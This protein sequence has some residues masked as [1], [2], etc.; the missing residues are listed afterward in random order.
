MLRIIPWI[1]IVMLAV[2][3][4]E[5]EEPLSSVAAVRALSPAEAARH[6]A[7]KLEATITFCGEPPDSGVFIQDN[8]AGIFLLIPDSILAQTRFQWKDRVRVEAVTDPG[9]YLP[10]LVCKSVTLV[11]RDALP[12]A[13]PVTPENF[14]SP[15]L[16]SRWVELSGV[17]S[18]PEP[19]DKENLVFTLEFYGLK[20][21]VLT[22]WSEKTEHTIPTLIQQSVKLAAIEASLYNTQRQLTGCYLLLPS[23][24]CIQVLN[25][26]GSESPPP[27]LA[28]DHLLRSDTKADELVRVQGTVTWALNDEIHLRGE[29][30]GLR[31]V[32]VGGNK[33]RPGDRVEAEGFASIAPFRPIF[34]ARK[35]TLL[36]RGAEPAP[37]L[38]MPTTRKLNFQ[39]SEFVTTGAEFLGVTDSL[40][41]KYL[42]CRVGEWFFEAILTKP[43]ALPSDLEP[44]STLQ[45][46][47]ICELIT[48][49]SL[50]RSQWVDGFRIRLRDSSD[51]KIIARPAW[52]TSRRLLGALAFTGGLG[53]VAFAWVFLLRRQVAA[54]TEAIAT[55]IALRATLGE[56]QRIARD[57]HDTL[58]QQMT[59]VAMQLDNVEDQYEQRPD[60]ARSALHLARKM[61]RHCRGETGNAIRDLRNESLTRLGLVGA[62]RE[63]LPLL[64]NGSGARLVFEEAGTPVPMDVVFENHFWR[65]AQE[66]VANA[67]HHSAATEIKVLIHY[68]AGAVS[69]AVHDNG[70]GF[71]LRTSPMK[72]HFG[73]LGMHERANK[74]N[75]TLAI[76]SDPG[77]GTTVRVTAD[78]THEKDQSPDC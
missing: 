24:D 20:I 21:K 69:L 63:M 16:E 49:R 28:L 18:N 39:Q 41:A 13:T 53:I 44:N 77:R 66:A 15:D 71:N 52:W 46:N 26:T 4:A 70:C 37:I 45:M 33:F 5:A 75:A 36:G 30:G 58:E 76:E 72:G 68:A 38:L 27:L 25:P 60:R 32:T 50:P 57:L 11:G 42:H 59:G 8:T 31:V 12:K 6:L 40:D 47:G 54:Q 29:G 74:M 61:L 65:L 48:T 62:L 64:V 3:A 78:L 73:L 34:R 10:Q 1:G 9:L 43:G 14:F 19:R 56:R 23:L 2:F 22:P 67:V 35:L 51:L 7:V 55:Q 17:V